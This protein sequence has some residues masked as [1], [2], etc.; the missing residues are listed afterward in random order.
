LGLAGQR[1]EPRDRLPVAN[2]AVGHVERERLGDVVAAVERDAEARA[3]RRAERLRERVPVD[4]PVGAQP[5]AGTAVQ[6]LLQGLGQRGLWA[7][8]RAREQL[9]EPRDLPPAAGRA[10]DRVERVARGDVVLAGRADPP[11]RA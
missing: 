8:G 10:E 5:A 3:E 4:L 9:A 1:A 11:A 2:L 6:L 7:G